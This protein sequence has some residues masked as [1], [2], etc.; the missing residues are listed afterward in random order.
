MDAREFVF[1]AVIASRRSVYFF[2]VGFAQLIG[3]IQFH[4]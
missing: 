3:R 1:S 2:S 4:C